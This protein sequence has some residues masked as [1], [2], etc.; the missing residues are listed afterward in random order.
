MKLKVER[1]ILSDV[2]LCILTIIQGILLIVGK[3]EHSWTISSIVHFNLYM[4]IGL[5]I[6][7]LILK[8]WKFQLFQSLF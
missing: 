1:I 2:I 3:I 7:T 8:K 5:E 4:I 6:V